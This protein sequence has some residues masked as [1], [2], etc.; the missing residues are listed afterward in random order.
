MAL[1]DTDLLLVERGGVKYHM[2]A[3][4]IADFL[5]A[6]NDFSVALYS[7]LGSVTDVKVG[8]RIFVA[9]ATG[10]PNV[11]S[12]WAIYRV[13]SVGPVTHDKVQEQESLDVTVVV[14][15]GYTASTS[16]GTVTSS[17]G[18]DATIPAVDG[19]NA[20]LATPAMFNNSHVPAVA[21]GTPTTNPVT[22]NAATQELDLNIGQLLA[23]P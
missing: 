12:G 13:S 16:S 7:D 18:T 20:G 5:G 3:D 2:T 8:D 14:N 15:L 11:A 23:L 22:V 1:Q 17:A 10:D 4:Q 21:A 19:T 9:D 6:V